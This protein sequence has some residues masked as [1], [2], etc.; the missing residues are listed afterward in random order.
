M[1]ELEMEIVRKELSV[2]LHSFFINRI[3]FKSYFIFVSISFVF[4]SVDAIHDL[5][6]DIRFKE[7]LKLLEIENKKLQNNKTNNIIVYTDGACSNNGSLNAL[8]GI[9]V[10]FSER[11]FDFSEYIL[12]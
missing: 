2:Y 5:T 3:L 1:K 11:N 4:V 8:G 6:N 9:G 10:Y 7:C 12:C